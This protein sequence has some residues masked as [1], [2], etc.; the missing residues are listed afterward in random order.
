MSWS[1]STIGSKEEAQAYVEQSL[2]NSAKM[3]D[4]YPTAEGKQEAQDCRDAKRQVLD[5]LASMSL[6][7]DS[8]AATGYLASVSAYGSRSVGSV[9]VSV[10]VT[11]TPKS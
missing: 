6:E 10:S 3:Y 8:Y 1:C 9:T 11:K 7:P 2:D 5:A 4:D